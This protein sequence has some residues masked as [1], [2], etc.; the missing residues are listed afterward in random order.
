MKKLVL[1][2]PHPEV[3]YG[4]ENVTTLVQM[5]LNLGYLAAL[6]PRDKWTVDIIDETIE[7]AVDYRSGELRFAGA[8]LVGVSAVSYQS[9]RA[10]DIARA[11]KKHNIPVVIGGPHASTIPDEAVRYADAAVVGE[12]EGIWGDL[13]RDLEDGR[14]KKQYFGGLTPLERYRDLYPDRELL[15]KKYNYK[16]SSIITTRGCPN[17][18]DFCAVPL[19]QGKKYRERPVEDVLKEMASTSYKG[20]MFAEDNFY[21]HSKKA[22]ERARALFKGMTEQNIIKDWFGF[23]ALNTAFDEETLKYMASSGCLGILIGIESLDEEVLKGINKHINLR[24]GVENYR[25]GIENLHRHGIVCW[26]SVIFGADGDTKD[27]F[28]RMTD[29]TL[30]AGMDILTFGVYTPM[31]MT[32]SFQRLMQE[33]RIFRNRFP[34]DWYYYN[35]NH[36]VFTPRDMTIDDLIEGLEYVYENLYSREALKARFDRT[37]KETNNSKNAMFAYRINI[38][39]RVVFKSVIDDLKALYDSGTYPGAKGHQVAGVGNRV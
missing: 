17:R 2:N 32:S 4:E 3:H 13:L 36:L 10:Y 37:L 16:Y 9:P 22:N 21:G 33:G 12:A 15:K 8:D 35:S 18:C 26:G 34:K 30:E 6:T 24:I 7:L 14:L 25:K 11:C 28:K 31:P 27:N 39:W 29:F 19:F 23:T 38:D 20:L 1:I 5:P